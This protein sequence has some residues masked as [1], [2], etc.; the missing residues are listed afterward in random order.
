MSPTCRSRCPSKVSLGGVVDTGKLELAET[1]AKILA[2]L[3]HVRRYFHQGGHRLGRQLG[4][5]RGG[6]GGGDDPG[7]GNQLVAVAVVAVRVGIDQRADCVGSRL[8]GAHGPQHAVGKREIVQG[9]HQQGLLPVDNQSRVAPAPGSARGQPGIHAIA[10]CLQAVF[11]LVAH[12]SVRRPSGVQVL[13][14]IGAKYSRYV[15]S[16]SRNLV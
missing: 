8:G 11:I 5:F 15:L 4:H 13:L 16:G 2:H 1:V 14:R 3:A 6:C 7:A 12:N 9:I 10:Q